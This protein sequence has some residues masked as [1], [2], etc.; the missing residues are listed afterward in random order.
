MNP[1]KKRQGQ[2][3]FSFYHR[4]EIMAE[5]KPMQGAIIEAALGIWGEMGKQRLIPITGRSMLPLIRDSD[6]VLVMHGSVGIRRG[7]VVVFRR[8]GKLFAHR[9]LSIYESN[10]GITFITKGDNVLQFDPP[11]GSNEVIGRVIGIKRGG[12]QI[13]LE[14]ATWR[15]GGWL[16]AVSTLALAK[17][18]SC[19]RIFNHK[20]LERRPG[21]FTVFLRRGMRFFSLLIRRVV[22]AALCRWKE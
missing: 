11:F 15:I 16:I 20:P 10:D 6:H 8:K 19:G 5:R 21:Q 18:R 3:G 12:R 4:E 14:T 22:F 9:A 17:L 13:S 2:I 1:G 7:D